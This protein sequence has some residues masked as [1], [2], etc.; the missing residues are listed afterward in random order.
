MPYNKLK[1]DS[2]FMDFPLYNLPDVN[3][4][5]LVFHGDGKKKVMVIANENEVENDLDFLR[6][7]LSPLGFEEQDVYLIITP[8]TA[9]SFTELC[10]NYDFNNLVL[11]GLTP[12]QIG[13]QVQ[14]K[15]Y[16]PLN[17]S[18]K[19]IMF[20]DGVEIFMEEKAKGG[21]RPKAK[22]LWVAL[23]SFLGC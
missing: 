7:V 14:A 19:Q 9:L 4:S 11:F 1:S 2:G 8:N 23:K 12:V 20:A 22:Q 15:L 21:A 17:I 10:Q 18:K 13:L 16:Q 3:N 5:T 6:N